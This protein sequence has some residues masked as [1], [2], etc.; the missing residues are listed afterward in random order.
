MSGGVVE[1]SS[2]YA[3]QIV[4]VKKRDGKLRI[5]IDF[6]CLNRKT[7]KDA[8][9]LPNITKALESLSC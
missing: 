6:H 1:S 9:P 3:L 8:S 4:L 7:I 5:C 2:L